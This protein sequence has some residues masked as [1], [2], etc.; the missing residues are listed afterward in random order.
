MI[1]RNYPFLLLLLLIF[2]SFGISQ[3]S[4]AMMKNPCGNNMPTGHN[5]AM[6]GKKST[7]MNKLINRSTLM[8]IHRLIPFEQPY[9]HAILIMPFFYKTYPGAHLIFMNS[10]ILKLNSNQIKQEA[11]IVKKVLKESV[12][13]LNTLNKSRKMFYMEVLKNNP[14]KSKLIKYE[15]IFENT[16]KILG[17]KI[18]SA[19]IDAIRI[20]TAQQKNRLRKMLIN[21]PV[22]NVS[23]PVYP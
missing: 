9:I 23:Y 14:S 8:K 16:E 7:L 10:K 13:L 3:S 2:I 20:L 5:A 19:H 15:K 21:W 4:F 6:A 18:I 1:R 22:V 17:E 12:P 11:M